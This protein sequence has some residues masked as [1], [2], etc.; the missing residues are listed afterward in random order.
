LARVDSRERGHARL[1]PL[2]CAR[3]GSVHWARGGLD[4]IL[5]HPVGGAGPRR[6]DEG[7]N[8]ANHEPF[9]PNTTSTAAVGRESGVERVES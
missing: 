7:V 3:E 6:G 2:G 1:L 5:L 4:R 9:T 8:R